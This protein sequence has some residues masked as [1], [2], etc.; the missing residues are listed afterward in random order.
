MR[1]MTRSCTFSLSTVHIT[2]TCY[3]FSRLGLLGTAV[4]IGSV[5]QAVFGENVHFVLHDESCL[6]GYQVLTHG[7][8]MFIKD[9][10]QVD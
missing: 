2:T 8:N 7:I 6:Q 5:A 3:P 10:L 9:L 1:T 4:V